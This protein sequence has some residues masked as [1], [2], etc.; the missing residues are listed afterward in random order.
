MSGE[1]PQ[2]ENG[3]PPLP[4]QGRPLAPRSPRAA[5][6]P[7]RVPLPARRS[8][9]ARH[10]VVIAGN[11]FFMLLV[12]LAVAAGAGLY[13]GKQHYD[14]PGPLQQDK[15]V[16]IARGLGSRA[17]AERLQS[18]GVI[19]E[20]W[21]FIGGV[22]VRK[23]RGE[24]KHG[25]YRFKA[26]ASIADVVDTMIE[27]KVVQHA[28]TFP[29]GLTSEQ[30]VARLLDTE[31]LSG[32]ISQIPRE[33]TL[34]PDTYK[35][36]RGMTREQMIRRMQRDSKRVLADVWAHRLPDLPL[37]TPQELVT[38]ASIVEKETGK[39]DERSRVAA[40][41]I[42]RLKR[43]MR[44]QSDPTI[45]YGLTGGKGSLGHAL[46]KSEIERPNPYNTYQIDGLPPGPIAN[47]GR[48]ALDAVANPARTK[49]LYFVADGTGGHVFSENYQ[50]HLKNVAHLRGLEK[51]GKAKAVDP[52]AGG[53]A[54]RCRQR[55]A[56]ERQA[57][58]EE[59]LAH[60]PEK[61]CPRPDRGW[62]PVFG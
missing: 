40:V 30:V 38:L 43:K 12:L 19:D 46:L 25:E 61:A 4:R 37:K 53:R 15:I 9:K 48:A 49:D 7:E 26:H 11:A 32:P 3:K 47:P 56:G 10:P 60:G 54:R 58:G 45:I 23:A 21:V 22:M 59:A 6:E 2:D 51:D 1:T 24:L 44:L 39:A 8:A 33:G 28:L 35:F 20:P 17:I 55:Q 57:Q 18:E 50:Q 27:G 14:A 41:F 42:N 5:L 29:E 34:L 36:T 31:A 62:Q 13:F 52:R 16:N